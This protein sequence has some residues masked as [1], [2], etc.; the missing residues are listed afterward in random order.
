[1]EREGDAGMS[2]TNREKAHAKVVQWAEQAGLRVESVS[3]P[4]RDFVIEL[5]E[6]DALP[7]VQASHLREDTAYVMIVGLVNIPDP[8]RRRLMS[9]DESGFRDLIWGIKMNLLS[10]GVDFTVHGSEKDPEAWEVQRSL[11]LQ[12]G[13]PGRFHEAYSSVKNALI[14][15]IWAY[16]RALDASSDEDPIE[17]GVEA[18]DPQASADGDRARRI[19]NTIINTSIILLSTLMD[20]FTQAMVEAAGSMASEMAGVLDGEESR[21]E[22]EKRF[23]E[24]APDAGEK[25]K[26]MISEARRDIYDQFDSKREEMETILD[27]KAFDTGPEIV[28]RYDHGLPKLSEELDD[29]SIAQYARLLVEE[30]PAFMEMFGE[31]VSWM[32]SLPKAED[33]E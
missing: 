4:G 17:L 18:I 2:S 22:V 26:A 28:D 29:A 25:M 20:G 16:K 31:L 14:G 21:L 8:D 9:R 11:F 15:V 24:E 10:A 5:H 13:G 27:D 7:R 12:D 32:D 33:K 6:N 23:Q 1:M 19:M 3:A 30:D